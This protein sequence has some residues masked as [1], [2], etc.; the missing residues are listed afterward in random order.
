MTVKFSHFHGKEIQVFQ[1][2]KKKSSQFTSQSKISWSAFVNYCN[3]R[4]L[5]IYF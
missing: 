4:L 2:I 1:P 3:A 5:I